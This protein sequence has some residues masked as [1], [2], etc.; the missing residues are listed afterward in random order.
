MRELERYFEQLKSEFEEKTGKLWTPLR[1]WTNE[2][3]DW[4]S[5][6]A[7]DGYSTWAM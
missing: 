4:T 3:W 5:D 6:E 7:E 1:A 2:D